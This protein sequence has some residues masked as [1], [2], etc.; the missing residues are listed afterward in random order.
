MNKFYFFCF[1]FHKLL[2]EFSMVSFRKTIKGI[3]FEFVVREELDDYYYL[4][5][6]ENI[7]FEMRKDVNGS[8]KIKG[9]T[10]SWIMELEENMSAAIIAKNI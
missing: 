5:N 7:N 10:K 2:G 1:R 3:D 6:A 8:W 9:K 4:V